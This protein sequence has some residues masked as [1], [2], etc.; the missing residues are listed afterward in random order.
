[1][2]ARLNA[3]LSKLLCGLCVLWT[4]YLWFASALAAKYSP[5]EVGYASVYALVALK[6]LSLLAV[7]AS[8]LLIRARAFRAA[9]LAAISPALALL[10]A[11]LV[12][13]LM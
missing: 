1:M 10:A 13:G 11:T 9:S 4:A 2:A 3:A 5:Q 8:V 6:Y 12:Q 7:I